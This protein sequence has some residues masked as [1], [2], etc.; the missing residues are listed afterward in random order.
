M[1]DKQYQIVRFF[2]RDDVPNKVTVRNL[3][4]EDAQAHCQDPETS[5]DTC[6]HAA[7]H[8]ITQKYGPWFDGYE[9]QQ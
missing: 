9:E 3:T 5:S 6:T 4:L 2:S 7:L 8:A 1:A